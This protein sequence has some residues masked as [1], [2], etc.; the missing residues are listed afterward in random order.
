MWKKDEIKLMEK[1]FASCL[2]NG[3]VPKL[4]KCTK[5]AE[6]YEVQLQHSQPRALFAWVQERLNTRRI[7]K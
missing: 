4:E 5:V 7:I 1:L 2:G 6:K 3:I